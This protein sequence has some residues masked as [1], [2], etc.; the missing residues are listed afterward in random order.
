MAGRKIFVGSLPDGVQDELVRTQMSQFGQIEDIFIKQG[1]EPGRQWA[2]VTFATADQAQLAKQ[3]C[4][5]IVTFPGA[6]RPCDVMIAKNQG[7]FGQQQEGMDQ[8]GAAGGFAAGGLAAPKKIF[9]GSLPDGISEETVR[10]EFMKYGMVEEVYM[11]QNCEPGRQW[12]FVT[13]MSPE[14]ASAAKEATDQILLFPGS[15]KACEV[16]LARNQGMFGQNPMGGAGGAMMA[17][18]PDSRPRKCFVGSLPDGIDEATLRAQLASYGEITDVYIKQ[19]CEPGRQWGFVTFSTPDQA[20]F[21]KESCD[22]VLVFPGHDRAIEVTM[23]K[24]QGMFG[25][26]GQQQPQQQWG[27]AMQ[28]SVYAAPVYAPPAAATGPCKIF[29]GSLP[30]TITDGGLR[31]EFSKYGQIVDV[32]LKTNCE[33]GRKWAFVTF[34]DPTQ[35]QYAKDSTDRVLYLPGSEKPCEVMLAKN[36]GKGGAAA[37]GGGGFGGGGFGGGAQP[38]PPT[39]PPPAHLTPWRMYKTAAGLPYYHNPVTGQTVWECP[40]ELKAPGQDAYGG[41]G[42]QAMGGVRYSPY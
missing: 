3:S 10:A 12:C 20:H 42:A 27:G 33:P 8:G 21:C 23:A 4:D 6:D 40:P 39:A 32:F 26:G 14:E 9:V 34:A 35:A 17:A 1:C 30:E 19:G 24:N 16:K 7:M 11:K 2:F 25:Q 36:Q 38:P 5:R 41:Y 29:V 15:I 28:Q 13:Y 37:G 18:M 22:R 31:A